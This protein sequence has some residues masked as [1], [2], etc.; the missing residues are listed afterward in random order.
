MGL[1]LEQ[2]L[3]VERSHGGAALS[4]PAG[5]HG[6]QGPHHAG[7]CIGPQALLL[8]SHAQGKAQVPRAL[9]VLLGA[10]SLFGGC[11]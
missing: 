3:R 10:S 6:T 2:C 8:Y 7:F 9:G 4:C 5:L 11:I 1:S